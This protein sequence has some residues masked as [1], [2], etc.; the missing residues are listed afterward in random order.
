M[1]D[2]SS[3]EDW[4]Q[5][6]ASQFYAKAR[7]LRLS[8]RGCTKIFRLHSYFYP[9][10]ACFFPALLN[11]ALVWRFKAFLCF[12]D[13]VLT[14]TRL[15]LFS[16]V[17]VIL[18]LSIFAG[19]KVWASFKYFPFSVALRLADDHHAVT[20]SL[21][22]MYVF[23]QSPDLTSAISD[24]HQYVV[25][26]ANTIDATFRRYRS[27][28][29]IIP[30]RHLDGVW[31]AVAHLAILK[32]RKDS[33]WKICV[34]NVAKENR[35]FSTLNRALDKSHTCHGGDKC[36]GWYCCK[37]IHNF[38][39]S[40][41]VKFTQA[42]SS[43]FCRWSSINKF[44]CCGTLLRW[45]G[46]R[47]SMTTA[48]LTQCAAKPPCFLH[49]LIS[50]RFFWKGLTAHGPRL[51]HGIIRHV[52]FIYASFWCRRRLVLPMV[53]KRCLCWPPLSYM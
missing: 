38:Y 29:F 31:S 19:W 11:R 12:L 28:L 1:A 18:P 32:S 6:S 25:Y 22:M 16:F 49:S 7:L 30:E 10:V 27:A 34:W 14:L 36:V 41:G 52:G 40:V 8:I 37:C 53:S 5:K 46:I 33:H 26:P 21:T 13:R 17:F 51:S 24:S 15:A 44:D 50:R 45:S 3:L 39:L 9:S 47:R 48:L 42:W 2:L 23:G 4:N 35:F 43:T 20:A